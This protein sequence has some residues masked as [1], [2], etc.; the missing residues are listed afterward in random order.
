MADLEMLN[1][2]CD[3]ELD[4]IATSQANVLSQLN[5]NESFIYPSTL[6]THFFV[7]SQ[8]LPSG[9]HWRNCSRTFLQ[10]N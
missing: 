7:F 10:K 1:T 9:H 2:T 6:I 5:S 3:A 4:H 8:L